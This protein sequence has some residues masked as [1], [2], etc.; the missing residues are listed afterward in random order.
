MDRNWNL[1]LFSTLGTMPDILEEILNLFP[2]PNDETMSASAIFGTQNVRADEM[3][4]N[5]SHAMLMFLP[6][7][8]FVRV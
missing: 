2:A 7:R 6:A 5:T 4:L 3:L 8:R 1:V